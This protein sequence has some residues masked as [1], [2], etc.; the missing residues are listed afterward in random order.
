MSLY[1]YIVAVLYVALNCV[2]GCV[3]PVHFIKDVARSY[4]CLSSA[5]IDS[6]CLTQAPT[7]SHPDHSV[8]PELRVNTF[9]V[10]KVDC[11][12]MPLKHVADLS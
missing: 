3:C 7:H 5:H 1:T 6:V 4:Q 8:T 10:T 2:C 9:C 12:F 11:Y